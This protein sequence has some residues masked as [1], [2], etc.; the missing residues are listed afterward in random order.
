[1]KERLRLRQWVGIITV[2]LAISAIA[3]TGAG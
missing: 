2:I 1:L 3:A